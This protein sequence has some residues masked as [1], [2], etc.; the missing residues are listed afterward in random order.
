[1][2]SAKFFKYILEFKNPSGTSRGILHTKET[3]ILEISENGKKES[4]NADFSVV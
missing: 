3:F 2:K 4:G 1:M